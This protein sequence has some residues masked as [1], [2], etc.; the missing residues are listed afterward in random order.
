[1]FQQFNPSVRSTLCWVTFSFVKDIYSDMRNRLCSSTVPKD[2]K[3]DI[4][5][6]LFVLC[7][8]VRNLE[9]KSIC[10]DIQEWKQKCYSLTMQLS[11]VTKY[12]D[13]ALEEIESTKLHMT[14][15]HQLVI[16]K[17]QAEHTDKVSQLSK[18]VHCLVFCKA[19]C[20]AYLF[21]DI[22]F[23]CLFLSSMNLILRDAQEL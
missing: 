2:F 5:R 20:C 6:I 1:M 11:Q 7:C 21:C 8:C 3:S 4:K 23:N 17:L 12:R 14:E 15:E 19:F 13:N 22:M 10:V 18:Q 16:E 9:N